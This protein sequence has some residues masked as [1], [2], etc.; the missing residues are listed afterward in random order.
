MLMYG[1]I[2]LLFIDSFVRLPSFYIIVGNPNVSNKDDILYV[3]AQV[4]EHFCGL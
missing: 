4:E 1:S 2:F 3:S